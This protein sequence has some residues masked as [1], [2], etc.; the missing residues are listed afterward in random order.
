[1]KIVSVKI[2]GIDCPLGYEMKRV[3]CSWKA[4]GAEGK[5]Q[6]WARIAVSTDQ[7]FGELCCEREGA[8]LDSAGV[9]LDFELQKKTRY[10]LYVE[11]ESDAGERA[12]S[13]VVWF[14]TAKRGEPWRGAWITAPAASGLPLF[15]KEFDA[16]EDLARAR[17]YISGLGLYEARING[18]RVSQER[19][20]PLTSDYREKIRYQTCDVTELIRAHNAIEVVCGDGWY[21]GRLGYE[22]HREVFGNQYALVAEL[23]LVYADGSRELLATD[24]SWQA[25]GS[26]IEASD[27]YDGEVLNRLLWE[28]RNNPWRAAERSELLDTSLLVERN[29]LPVLPHERLPV[30]EL[31]HTP[32][33]ECVLDFGQNLA[34][35][36]EF[37]SAGLTKGAKITLDFGEILQDGN[38]FNGNYRTAKAQYVYVADG[39]QELVEPHFTFYG[40]RYVRVSGWQGE[41]NPAAFTARALYSD[42]E[43]SG[44]LSTS[45]GKINR[46]IQNCEWGQRS[47][48]IDLPMD[49]PQRDER[50]GW[51]GDAQVFAPTASFQRYT[52]VFYQKYL[53]DLHLEQSKWDGAVPNFIPNYTGQPGG[54]AIW[55]DAAAFL[56]MT[57]YEYYGDIDQL[58]DNYP[59]MREWVDYLTRES[60]AEGCAPL[61]TFGM[62]FGDWLAMDGITEQSFKGGTDEYFLASAYYYASAK[63]TAEAAAALGEETEEKHYLALAEHIYTAILDEYFSASGRLCIDTQAAYVVCLRFQIYRDKQRVID[64]LKERLRKDCYRIKCGFAGAPV[65]CQTLGENGMELLANRILFYE[66]FPGW[67]RCVNLGAT[68]IWERWNSVLDNGRVSGTGMNSLNHYAYGSV[69]EYLYR[70]I[71]GIEPLAPGFLKARLA[72]KPDYRMREVSCVYDSVHGKYEIKYRILENGK[73]YLRAVVPFSCEAELVLPGGETHLLSA[74]IY[75]TEYMPERDYRK[76]FSAESILSELSGSPEALEIVR[77]RIPA[78]YGMLQGQDIELLSLSLRDMLRMPYMGFERTQVELAIGEASEVICEGGY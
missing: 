36:V 76:P 47:N 48:F 67:L 4:E 15:F 8:D 75:E 3:K 64:G 39:R 43:R 37:S 60:E 54:A 12:K 42:L 74:G 29:A 31:I 52:G 77:A 22:G 33:G 59:M 28:E 30:K 51:T 34:G 27:L 68:T 57:L 20:L 53:E 65:L 69:V 62:Q 11:A 38:F 50:L 9:R 40:F 5:K 23:E 73:I 13:E 10:Y 46:L 63:K 71:A 41:L 14:E 16:R 70:Q 2:N 1:M 44:W 17:L 61:I 24:E 66:G 72:P 19:L 6:V 32:A 26:D 7:D 55:G 21:K 78:A 58:R 49:C 25:K 45:N 18:S 35:C 56:P